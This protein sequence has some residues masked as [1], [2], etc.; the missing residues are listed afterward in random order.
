M[1]YTY[2]DIKHFKG[3]DHVR[4]D[5]ARTPRAR[6][7]TLVGLNESGKTTILDA[8]NLLTY[9]EN[10]L[11]L[12]LPGYSE[13]D[14]HDLVPIAKRSNFNGKIVIEVGIALEEADVEQIKSILKKD[15]GI[16]LSSIS[17]NFN[18][19]QSYS[20]KASRVE[21]NQPTIN[22]SIKLRGRN[23]SQKRSGDLEK[24]D[25]QKAVTS[26]KGLL[27]RI[28]YFPNF[29]FE[30]PDKIYL[31]N[32]PSEA[33]KHTFYRTILQDILDAIG[34]NTN[35]NDHVLA[36]LKSQ[37]E[38]EKRNL[39]SVLLKMGGHIT[40]SVFSNWDRIFKR[41]S[42]GKEIVVTAATDNRGASYLQLR[43]KQNNEYYEIS[44]RSLGFRWFFS[45]LLLTQYRGFRKAEPRSIVFL[46]DEPASNLHPSAQAQ[47]LGSF[48]ALPTGCDLVYT[49]HSHHM[50]NP[51]WLEGAYVVRNEGID[52]S[53]SD[54]DY[55]SHRTLI[56]L[57]KYRK[58][59]AEH[60]NQSTYFQPILDVLDY[61]P[62]KL[63]NVPDVIM[64][65]GKNDF[66]VLRFIQNI[67]KRPLI[68]FMPGGGAGSLS[69]MIRIYLSWGRNFIVLLDSD[70]EGEQQRKR[71]IDEF[72]PILQNKIMTLGDVDSTWKGKGMEE[73][74]DKR[75][76]LT[77]QNSCYPESGSF[78]KTHF[79]R[80]IQELIVTQKAVTLAQTTE[81]TFLR[82]YSELERRITIK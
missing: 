20:F 13:Q 25:W 36:R 62:A 63:E 52:Y 40:R 16:T 43:L 58:F 68:N 38:F 1:R 67:L 70:T 69:P 5:I 3:I 14:I 11:A 24:E 66:Y 28:V 47:L 17:D 8:I 29:L 74:F 18:I 26:I 34:E 22:W 2:F 32:P 50:I 10:L 75:D 78:N 53:T 45:Y 9:R 41:P 48:T 59:A 27:P 35:L 15:H 60:P 31:E 21:A 46:L 73:L 39:D 82:L 65:E 64:L 4:L 19:R 71:Y 72:G 42:Q 49:T 56:T 23:S 57:H 30:F 7:C 76:R 81:D 12:D 77:I 79:A 55:T 51:D 37:E 44:E 33:D 80:A 6:V 61:S 54:E